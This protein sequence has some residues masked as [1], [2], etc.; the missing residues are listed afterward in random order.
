[1]LCLQLAKDAWER[2]QRIPYFFKVVD[3]A[4]TMSTLKALD[5]MKLRARAKQNG[6]LTILQL[7]VGVCQRWLGGDDSVC[8]HVIGGPMSQRMQGLV[9]RMGEEVVCP[10]AYN[11]VTEGQ[12]SRKKGSNHLAHRLHRDCFSCRFESVQQIGCGMDGRFCITV[13]RSWCLVN[14][15]TGRE[16]TQS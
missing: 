8:N 2:G 13:Y 16:K 11:V 6:W 4:E 3:L 9:R 15:R 12:T 14:N 1:M 10:A 5:W 7:A